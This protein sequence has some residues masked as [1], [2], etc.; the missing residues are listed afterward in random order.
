[1]KRLLAISALCSL[2]LSVFPALLRPLL[3]SPHVGSGIL[4]TLAGK[5]FLALVYPPVYLSERL[6]WY[7]AYRAEVLHGVS[8]FEPPS[9]FTGLWTHLVVAFPFWFISFVLMLIAVRSLLLTARK[10]EV[11]AP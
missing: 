4:G 8:V 7:D 9:A 10:H 11:D 5:V 6:G 3:F 1:M 2:F